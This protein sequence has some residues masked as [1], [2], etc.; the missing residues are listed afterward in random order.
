M[1]IED[2]KEELG[3][4]LHLFDDKN[5]YLNRIKA[6][7]GNEFKDLY[8]NKQIYDSIKYEN[9]KTIKITI[10]YN[11]KEIKYTEDYAR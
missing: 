10:K 6:N 5:K 1:V 4:A 9:I 3:L 2:N 7:P 8:I 11:S